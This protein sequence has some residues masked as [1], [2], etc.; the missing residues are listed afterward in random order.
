MNNE[1]YKPRIPDIMEIIFDVCYLVFALAAGI[2]FFAKSQGKTVF[3]LY[4]ILTL[5]L[6]GGDAFHLVPRIVRGLKG[7]NEKIKKQLGLGLQISSITMTVFYVLLLYIWKNTFPQLTPPIQIVLAIWISAIARIIICLL[8]QNNWLSGNGNF[9]LSILRNS[10]FLTTGIGVIIL[11]SISGKTFDYGLEKMVIA[12]IISFA[13]YLPVT[14]FSKKIP[15]IG[16][17]MIPKT[18]AY[19]WMI[20]MGLKLLQRI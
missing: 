3:I 19:I 4:G 12:I 11:Y 14:V 1:Y 2:I 16:M 18:C 17:L 10:I 20:V 5:T 13:C 15:A 9:S 8:S 6:F 7:S